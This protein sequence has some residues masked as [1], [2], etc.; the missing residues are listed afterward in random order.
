MTNKTIEQRYKKLSQ[1]EHVLQ[2]PE[3]YIG[4]INTE[5]KK[6]FI[7]DDIENVDNIKIINKIVKYNPGFIKIFDEIVTNASDHYIRTGKVK[8]IKINIYTDHIVVENDGPG[9][10]VEIHKEHKIYI[11]EMIFGNLLAGENFD[12]I[13]DRVVGGRNGIGAKATNIF[14]KRFIVETSDGKNNYYQ[15]FSDNL[16]VIKKPQISK[17][18][19]NYTRITYYPDFEKFGL[20]S[21]TPELEQILMKRVVDISVYCPKVKVYYNDKLIPMKTFKDY[22]KMYLTPEMEMFYERLNND[23]EVGISL[24]SD[25]MFQQVSMVNGI[26]TINGGSHVNY[27]TNQIVS[28][29]IETLE[30]K[31]KKIKIKSN[32]VKNKLFIFLNSKVINPTFDSQTKET[33][34]NKL[35]QKD[36]GNVNVSDKLIKQLAQSNIVEDILNYI[37]LKENAE[38]KKLNKGKISKVK[39]KKLDDANFA[40]TSQSEKCM[41]FLAEGDSAAGTVLTGFASTGRDYFGCFPLKG[42]PLNVRDIPLS[43]I[44]SKDSKEGEEI[45]YIVDALG[46][47]FGKKYTSTK[48][49]RYGKLVIM[50]DADNDG[51]HIKGLIINMFETFWKELLELD[52]LY[53][54]VTPIVK[55]EKGKQSKFFYKLDEYEK[56]KKTKQ[57]DWFVT[58]YKGLGTIEP[59]EAKYF[60]K[61]INKHLI[62]FH[63]DKPEE[64]KE[65]IDLVFRKKRSDDRKNWLLNY[66]PGL[67][68]DKFVDKTTF[69]SFFN[70]EFIEFSMADNIRSIPS[71]V[72]GL[73]PSQR[74]VLYT[75]LKNNY[76]NKIKV[77]NLSGAVMEK[78]SY[79]HG[80][81]SLEDT[82]IKMAQNIVGTN[83]INLL[84]PLGNF[85]TRLKGGSDAASS[86]YIFT[87]LSDITRNIFIDKD[88][89]ILNY[90]EDDGFPIEPQWY[91]P[92]IPM[93]LVNG[94]E[95]IGTG[96][97]TKI[98]N[99]DP[100]DIIKYLVL[101]I[102]DKETEQLYPKYKGFK[103]KIIFDADNNRYI[104]RGIIN[105]INMSTL[106]ISEL[107]I[108]MWNDKYYEILDK[109][110]E[111]KVIKDYTKNDTD[112][113]VDITINIARE[114]LKKIEDDNSLMDVFKLETYINLS[115][116][117]L[118]N[119]DGQIHKYESIDEIINEFIEVRLEY[120]QKRKDYI[121]SQLEKDRK[122]LFNKMKFINEILKGTIE[123]NN[124]KKDEIE[125]KMEEL[126]I[127]KI[128]NSYSYLLNMSLISL[129][130]EKLSELKKIYTE[131]KEEIETLTK[132]S[133]KQLWLKDLND[134]YNKLQMI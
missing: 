31:N 70:K 33:L 54:F 48:E 83:N 82:I 35:T 77:S 101:K 9:V 7:I 75:M 11:P 62:K 50:S 69:V 37:Q 56:W 2:R 29:L 14:S 18:S 44:T 80:P 26:S 112:I 81:Q 123:L 55:I 113:K 76:K 15:E 109:L 39:I 8:Y 21:I 23:W 28:K 65:I 43:K 125:K 116:M 111:D 49:L 108:G 46:L 61:N 20:E 30:K 119:K 64:T 13:E 57:S 118:F 24:S 53:E 128:D 102:K 47:E 90:L 95:G 36:I 63:Y 86:R 19:K 120:Y 10:P 133:I 89:N 93:V 68:I 99:Y 52:F 91:I 104:T 127:S 5:L 87:I 106:N 32:D 42:K 98:P 103:G 72:D 41:L 59:N 40:G 78:S 34:T 85:G 38:L 1:R 117:H 122:I 6:S 25:D 88:D 96:W 84:Q 3:T 60:F 17:S 58:Y 73:K 94:A 74:K 105:K 22:M 130:T 121:L 92:I 115:N 134:L 12:D 114:T 4:S 66:K 16:N 129:T 131:K 71:V 27:I 79:H 45:R 132:T 100:N 110:I 124:K 97:S 126:E 51:S 67:K 107:P